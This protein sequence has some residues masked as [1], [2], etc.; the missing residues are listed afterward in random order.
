MLMEVNKTDF[1]VYLCSLFT[2]KKQEQ[3]YV[4]NQISV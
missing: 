1:L 4:N 2:K 3:K